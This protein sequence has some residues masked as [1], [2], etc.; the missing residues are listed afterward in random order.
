MRVQ[1][2]LET[3]NFLFVVLLGVYIRIGWAENYAW[4]RR[5]SN[6]RPLERLP[7]ALPIELRGQVSSVQV[8][9]I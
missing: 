8:C 5:E 4:P 9:D 1:I 6:L 3:S 2:P 7:N